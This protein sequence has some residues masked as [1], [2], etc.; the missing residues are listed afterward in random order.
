VRRA[1]VLLVSGLTLS[2]LII[3]GRWAAHHESEPSPESGRIPTRPIASEPTGPAPLKP[4]DP[5]PDAPLL[6]QDGRTVHLSDFK[7]RTLVLSF[8]YT[9][10]NMSTMCPMATRKLREAQAVARDNKMDVHFLVVSFDPEDS[11]DVL[12]DYAKRQEVDLSNWDFATAS[13]EVVGPLA[14]RFNTYY[15]RTPGGAYEHNI[16]VAIV[17]PHGTLRDE[18]FGTDWN[19][20]EFLRA[21]REAHP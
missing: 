19:L 16:N 21:L 4:G 9:R 15:R 20:Q 10:C 11:P 8:I 14:R 7:G 17:D 3:A 6:A 18:F 5:I 1:A 12:R 2:G 13:S